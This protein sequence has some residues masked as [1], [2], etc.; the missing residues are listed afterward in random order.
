ML[1]NILNEVYAFYGLKKENFIKRF[2]ITTIVVLI[3]PFIWVF[4]KIR[5]GLKK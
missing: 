2:F 3:I 4:K 1:K 5:M